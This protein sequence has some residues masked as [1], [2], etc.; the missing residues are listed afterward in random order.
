MPGLAVQ[1]SL[2][3]SQLQQEC[4]VLWCWLKPAILVRVVF[5]GFIQ[6]FCEHEEIIGNIF[7]YC[8]TFFFF[9]SYCCWIHFGVVLKWA[10]GKHGIWEKLCVFLTCKVSV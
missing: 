6:A 7:C 10:M 5:K 1:F 2:Y 9:W 8:L 3:M 4:E